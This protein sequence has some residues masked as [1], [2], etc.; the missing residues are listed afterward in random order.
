MNFVIIWIGVFIFTVL[1]IY[2][3][4]SKW[5]F[6]RKSETTKSFHLTAGEENEWRRAQQRYSSAEQKI[7]TLET[8]IRGLER[9]G[10]GL[11]KNKKGKF[12][13]RSALGKKLNKSINAA[14]VEKLRRNGDLKKAQTV[15]DRLEI[16][17]LT[18]ALPWIE[19]ESRRLAARIFTF[20]FAGTSLVLIILNLNMGAMMISSIILVGL[21]GYYFTRRYFQNLM[22]EKLGY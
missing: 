7:R 18:R 5:L 21:G 15:I 19:S 17:E 11:R 3:E 22:Y 12:D 9:K 2:S 10:V 8:E 13:N 4:V 16:L 1:W 20:L 14:R 6:H